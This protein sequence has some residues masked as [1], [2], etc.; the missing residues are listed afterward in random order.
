MQGLKREATKEERE[1]LKQFATVWYNKG[2]NIAVVA[3]EPK[4][5]DG[6]VD[7]LKRNK[8]PAGR[9][10][11]SEYFDNKNRFTLERIFELIDKTADPAIAFFNGKQHNSLV[12]ISIDVDV[13]NRPKDAEGVK[14]IYN[15]VVSMIKEHIPLTMCNETR[16]GLHLYLLV[17]GNPDE[18]YD[19]L[20]NIQT[21]FKILG[22]EI[23]IEFR[24]KNNLT[25]V[26]GE[27]YG[28]LQ[29]E[30]AKV[31]L[32]RM[33]YAI[34]AVI[35]ALNFIQI[36]QDDYKDGSRNNII[37][38][39]SAVQAKAG[40]PEIVALMTNAC[41]ATFYHDEQKTD[42]IVTT[43][44]TYAKY[45]DNQ[46][47]DDSLENYIGEKKAKDVKDYYYKS[48]SKTNAGNGKGKDIKEMVEEALKKAEKTR[49]QAKKKVRLLD[50]DIG[51]IK[52]YKE[53]L[54]HNTKILNTKNIQE[55]LDFNIREVEDI[56]LQLPSNSNTHYTSDLYN[57]LYSKIPFI[58]TNELKYDPEE[59]TFYYFTG[60]YY[61]KIDT[62]TLL[63]VLEKLLK[64]Y[65][66]KLI[67]DYKASKE[68]PEEP[69]PEEGEDGDREEDEGE[70][71]TPSNTLLRLL[72]YMQ[73]VHDPSRLK[74][75]IEY[76]QT[77][78]YYDSS[79]DPFN[80]PDSYGLTD[81]D[82]MTVFEDCIVYVDATP[83]TTP[84][85]KVLEPS[86]KYFVKSCLPSS[87]KDKINVD[88]NS[89]SLDF[90][91]STRL[92]KYFLEINSNNEKQA[93]TLLAIMS[94]VFFVFDT[95]RKKVYFL[96][97]FTNIGKS[98]LANL[99]VNLLGERLCTE[100]PYESLLVKDKKEAGRMLPSPEWIN[101]KDARMIYV[102]EP[103]EGVRFGEHQ[104]KV[105]TGG[106]LLP[107]RLLY[108][109][110][111]MK[112]KIKGSIFILTNHYPIFTDKSSAMKDRVV[113]VELRAKFQ[114]VDRYI[115]KRILEEGDGEGSSISSSKEECYLALF[116]M[117]KLAL[118]KGIDGL[119]NECEEITHF[120][121]MVW[122]EQD[123][124]QWYIDE[125]LK[126]VG[127][128]R[129]I[130]ISEGLYNNYKYWCTTNGLE[131]VSL[132]TFRRRIREKIPSDR[133]KKDPK[134]KNALMLI[135]Y[136]YV[137]DTD[138][139]TDTNNNTNINTN[140]NNSNNNSSN[141][142]S[143]KE[144]INNSVRD[145]SNTSNVTIANNVKDANDAKDASNA[146]IAMDAKDVMQST[147]TQSTPSQPSL[148][149]PSLANDGYVPS[150]PSDLSE[151]RDCEKNNNTTAGMDIV[152]SNSN[153]IGSNNSNGNGNG[154]TSI[155][156]T[157]NTT[158]E[159]SESNQKHEDN[160]R[161]TLD[162]IL[163]AIFSEENGGY[164]RCPICNDNARYT[165]PYTFSQHVC[166]AHARN[167]GTF[168]V[169]GMSI[170]VQEFIR[171][172]QKFYP[173]TEDRGWTYYIEKMKEN[174]KKVMTTSITTSN[175]NDSNASNTNNTSN[176]RKT[177]IKKTI[178]PNSITITDGRIANVYIRNQL[179]ASVRHLGN[180]YYQCMH[181]NEI[182]DDS[183]FI[184]LHIKEIFKTKIKTK[185]NDILDLRL[186]DASPKG[187]M[188]G[189]LDV[190][191]KSSIVNDTNVNSNSNNNNNDIY[192]NS[193]NNINNNINDKD[194]YNNSITIR[195]ED[196]KQADRHYYKCP[197]CWYCTDK[198]D[199]LKRHLI[200]EHKV[201]EE[202]IL[203]GKDGSSNGNGNSN[204]N[205]SNNNKVVIDISTVDPEACK[206]TINDFDFYICPVKNC[207]SFFQSLGGF[208]EH[209]LDMHTT[210]AGE[211]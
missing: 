134:R 203:D 160:D 171:L 197:M 128:E 76:L 77:K 78:C 205:C 67:L 178:D 33:D 51:L 64:G 162:K 189:Y 156:T 37:Y 45:R 169:D 20:D 194:D 158:I 10:P 97:G 152:N 161:E 25:V 71:T 50:L 99:F 150:V 2:F 210:T 42:R 159:P 47:L 86:P 34:Q 54:E 135:G 115:L 96:Y 92:W 127:D 208:K 63:K 3:L 13:K 146:T 109:N 39:L 66:S 180:H 87:I 19:T 80:Q 125:G 48:K 200:E 22:Q 129:Q 188:Y 90:V 195:L 201:K 24:I 175:I 190:N 157:T 176:T 130:D 121:K 207:R 102:R 186:E 44:N 57:D 53:D 62:L 193:N 38:T 12:F 89:I 73:Y 21:N 119:I 4:I 55:V 198:A 147:Q 41:I 28:E 84:I 192:T 59:G 61:K 185:H 118:R 181:C 93:L 26:A 85:L 18:I 154:N 143:N 32:K 145:A 40:I 105:A 131:P 117:L 108:S 98:T 81:Y 68:H 182:Y 114:E 43:K 82:R 8:R 177:I 103:E 151:G 106:D 124:I 36:V 168:D 163:F 49:R 179:I 155:V 95:A 88:I 209:L 17:E 56:Y 144:T 94:H 202:N 65:I 15:D 100:L 136:K 187:T 122:Y 173:I 137:T 165:S 107:A 206:V 83:K 148:A 104:L 164:F 35:G 16:C 167:Y 191:Y 52:R 174:H 58:T 149:L 172:L 123:N 211:G 199:R 101:I 74:K 110:E 113:V 27:G 6:I 140:N 111:I 184:M 139:N 5:K 120:T 69:E 141:N 9:E 29:N 11:I 126:Y 170:N 79:S 91:K 204:G 46:A 116:E 72:A 7:P 112:F 31:E 142:N 23:G 133:I 14:Q 30:L 70:D 138:T 166:Y 1:R 183:Y 153:G 60:S 196:C 75:M 132:D